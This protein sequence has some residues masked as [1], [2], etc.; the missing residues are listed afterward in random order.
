MSVIKQSNNQL[1]IGQ[2]PNRNTTHL[3]VR[4]SMKT[5]RVVDKNWVSP[6]ELSSIETLVNCSATLVNIRYRLVILGN[7]WEI[8]THFY[9]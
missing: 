1:G 4:Q 8:K 6:V 2:R 9:Q 3:Q 5:L 7:D